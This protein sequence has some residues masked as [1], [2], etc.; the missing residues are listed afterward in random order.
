MSAE[1]ENNLKVELMRSSNFDI[2][3]SFNEITDGSEITRDD[4]V[5]A[6]QNVLDMPHI[7]ILYA[8]LCVNSTSRQVTYARFIESITPHGISH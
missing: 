1:R 8:K 4:L 3:S 5:R 7:D 6:L 2:N